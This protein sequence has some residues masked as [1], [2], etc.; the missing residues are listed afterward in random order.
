MTFA[1]VVNSEA[2]E[3]RNAD[4]GMASAVVAD[5]KIDNAQSARCAVREV[6]AGETALAAR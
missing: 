4:D 1:S 5:A 3:N 6:H 2:D